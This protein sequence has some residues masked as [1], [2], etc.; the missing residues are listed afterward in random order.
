MTKTIT[1]QS[2]P[3]TAALGRALA[4]T[5][6]RGSVVLL[7]GDL[8]AGKTAFVR[9]LAEG[10]GVSRDEVSSPTFT[11]VQEYRG[12]RLPLFHADLFRIDDPREIDDLGLDEIA[13]DGVLAI[14]WAEKIPR[15]PEGTTIVRIRHGDGDVRLI[16]I[17]QQPWPSPDASSPEP[18]PR[19]HATAQRLVALAVFV[20]LAVAHT[21][22]LASNPAHLS[23]NDNGDTVLNTWAIAWVAHELPR[24]PARLFDA[25]IFYPERLTLA[26]SEAMIV[27]SV[28]AM[29]ILAAGGSPVLAYNLVLMA[30]FALT[31]W[32]FCLL[33]RRW[34]G[35]W[36]AGYVSGSL[37]AFNAHVLVRLPHLQAQ[38][39][40][41]VALILFA[42]DRLVVSRRLRDAVWL[43]VG[44]ALQGLTSV[45]LLVFT[46]WMLLFAVLG[47]A[48]EWLRREPVRM[49]GLFAAA[50]AVGTLILA[51]YLFAYYTL[52]RLTGV[53]RTVEEARQYAATWANYL[54]SGSRLHYDLWSHRFMGASR[55]SNF[56]GVT[57]LVLV[58]LAIAWPETRRDPRVQMCLAAAAG[59]A[60]VS[61][62]PKTPIYPALHG[63]IPL[64]R[65]IR[66]Q[67]HL[68]QIV[69]L[70]LA[71]VAGF[72]VAGLGRRWRDTRRWL[73]A[74]V[75][76][77]G[78]VNLE[79][80]RAP[81]QYSPFSRIPPIYDRL[82]G[83]RG[84]VIVEL[85]FHAPRIFFANAL[86]ML[87]STR[88]WRPMLNG[89]SGL[90]PDSYD[91]TYNAILGF[92]DDASL[93]AL[94]ERGVTHII[95]HLDEFSG[96][97]GHDRYEAILHAASLQLMAADGDI[98]IFRLR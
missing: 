23:R 39:V 47:R 50:A 60:A 94:H 25:N 24:H 6:A 92:P 2:E 42:L 8:G 29:P 45:Y 48:R 82:A 46:T 22:P 56:P 74:G 90:R 85:P 20:L 51:P 65:A 80:L 68:G 11:L 19:P 64:F 53:E 30:G 86:Y 27:Q 4:A 41:F 17:A 14:E 78:F 98:Q 61:M 73:A 38:H 21:W 96:V 87:Y 93:F 9:G 59:C 97:F 89:Y 44:F 57:A 63:L 58:A 35:S 81:I 37:A 77:C 1:T 83:E 26:Y 55:S 3:E 69:L 5:L 76:L 71:V 16:D 88:H 10:L 36:S 52:H 70:M 75:V 18:A 43:G 13:A 7:Y 33:V 62:L 49:I 95:V 84:A 28:M 12:G 31:G 15:A 91:V 72:G 66:V 32:A 34:T 40:E 54:L 79:A 67:A